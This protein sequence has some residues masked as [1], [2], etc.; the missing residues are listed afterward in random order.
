M[1]CLTCVSS[2]QHPP[3]P[4]GTTLCLP[5]PPSKHP[6]TGREPGIVLPGEWVIREPGGV[7]RVYAQRKLE[8]EYEPW[9]SWTPN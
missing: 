8:A 2:A 5:A 7:I 6:G 1:K 3:R 9:S 4:H